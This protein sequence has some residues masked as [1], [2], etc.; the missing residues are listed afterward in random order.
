LFSLLT[1]FFIFESEY[2]IWSI[3]E[4]YL[5]RLK[6]RTSLKKLGN[7]LAYLFAFLII[8][9]I[10][11]ALFGFQSDA[12][13]QAQVE[14]PQS[15]VTQLNAAD[16]IYN[17]NTSKFL[18]EKNISLTPYRITAEHYSEEGHLK[19][20]GNVTSNHT[21]INTYLSDDLLQGK[22]NGTFETPDGDKITWIS[23]DIG[24]S[25]D[26]QWEYYGIVLFNNTQ[27]ESFSLLNNSIGLKRDTTSSNESDYIWLL[28]R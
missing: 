23:S 12:E 18:G 8:S 28:G 1:S 22:G 13:T 14:S 15:D 6:L 27:S 24:R 5:N 20:I 7:S 17:S 26:D 21:F 16:S 25:V 9:S 3:Y 19:G 10:T 2:S 11:G 4:I